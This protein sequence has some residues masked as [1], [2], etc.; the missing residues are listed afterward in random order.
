MKFLKRF[1]LFLE[2]DE[3]N[4]K[5]SPEEGNEISKDNEKVNKESLSMIQKDIAYYRSKKD[6]MQK[7]IR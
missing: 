3:V 5:E 7:N 1:E 2:Q 4:I 6:V